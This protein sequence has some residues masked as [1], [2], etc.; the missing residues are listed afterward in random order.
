M[1]QSMVIRSTGII[2][3]LI[4]TM[5]RRT[6]FDVKSTRH[7]DVTLTLISHKYTKTHTYTQGLVPKSKLFTALL[8]P[9]QQCESFQG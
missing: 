7:F 5:P 9:Y 8:L 2:N 6:A 1:T 3:Q 4:A